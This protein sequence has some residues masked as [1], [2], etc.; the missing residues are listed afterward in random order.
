M[1]QR[2]PHS[3]HATYVKSEGS[4]ATFTPG[5]ICA[6][7]LL[8]GRPKQPFEEIVG[9]QVRYRDPRNGKTS[10]YTV[11]DY[12][13]SH[14]KGTYYVITDSEGMEEVNE[15]EMRGTSMLA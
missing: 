2:T 10:E 8:P 3:E 15:E 14:L 12:I 6:F 9:K 7:K 5:E 11:T 13:T 4:C 1:Q